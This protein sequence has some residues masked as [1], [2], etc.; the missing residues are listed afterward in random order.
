MIDT[1]VH[2]LREL[3]QG[4]AFEPGD[5]GYADTCTLFNAA[6]ERRPAMVVRPTTVADVAEAIRVARR[7]RSAAGGA[8]RRSLCGRLVAVRRRCGDR[9]AL[10]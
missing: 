9:Y 3:I 6:I 4:T 8:K 7:N 10:D 1:A 2:E 5:A